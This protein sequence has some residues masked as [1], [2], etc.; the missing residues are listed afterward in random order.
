MHPFKKYNSINLSKFTS[1][2][3]IITNSKYF[4]TPKI[5]LLLIIIYN[6]HSPYTPSH[7]KSLIYFLT[8]RSA[9]I[10][11]FIL[12]RIY[13]IWS[14]ALTSSTLHYVSQFY[15]V[16]DYINTTFLLVAYLLI[17]FFFLHGYT[18]FY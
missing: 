18:T 14:L 1:H 13:N 5:K 3:N 10:G 6:H 16:I 7:R 9:Y 12:M 4:I 8:H 15:R 17:I 11:C 2:G